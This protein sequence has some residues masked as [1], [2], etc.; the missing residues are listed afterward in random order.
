KL[1]RE[2][3]FMRTV[4]SCLLP[5]V[6]LT[7]TLSALPV[8]AAQPNTP[9]TPLTDA[10]QSAFRNELR[11]LQHRLDA[12]SKTPNMS[13][14]RC[15]DAQI[16]VKGVTWALDF[17]PINDARCRALV[18]YGLKRA[19][20]RVEALAAGSQPWIAHR[21]RSVRGFISAVDNTAQPYGIAVPADYDP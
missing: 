11:A 7:I 18:A 12:L 5:V 19:H 20:E 2:L 6:A 10:E 21:G 15:A 14:D 3:S 13:P 1:S 8:V 16:F 17:G 4:I 9:V